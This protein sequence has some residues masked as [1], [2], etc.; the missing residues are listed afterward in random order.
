VLVA[1]IKEC[2]RCE[3]GLFCPSG[4]VFWQAQSSLYTTVSSFLSFEDGFGNCRCGLRF[5]AKSA[6]LTGGGGRW[7]R[8]RPVG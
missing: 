6:A 4:S 1:T 7:G 3:H 2:E 8:V 5:W